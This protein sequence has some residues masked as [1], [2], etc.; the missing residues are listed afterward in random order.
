MKRIKQ[1]F[2]LITCMLLLL[3]ACYK[4][5]GSYNYMDSNQVTFL[6]RLVPYIMPADFEFTIT[7]PI[8]LKYPAEDLN[9]IF[10]GEWKLNGIIIGNEAIL[11]H[12][13][14]TPGDYK[15]SVKL[16]DKKTGQV[17]KSKENEY[18]ISVKY[19]YFLGWMVLSNKEGASKLSY[20]YPLSENSYTQ[21]DDVYEKMNN[22]ASLGSNPYSLFEYTSYLETLKGDPKLLISQ[23]S[24]NVTLTGA[25]LK[26]EKTILEEFMTA[27]LASGLRIKNLGFKGYFYLIQGEDN[28]LYKKI[29]SDR[30]DLYSGKYDLEIFDKPSEITL[31][32]PFNN[33]HYSSKTDKYA[34]LYDQKNSRFIGI[35]VHSTSNPGNITYFNN[36]LSPPASGVLKVNNMGAGTEV[37]AI[38]STETRGSGASSAIR[39]LIKANG[40]YFLHSFTLKDY[41]ASNHR[42]SETDQVAF[43]AANLL[44]NKSIIQFPSSF[45]ETDYF[46]FTAGPNNEQLYVYNIKT[47]TASL[48]YT[49]TTAIVSICAS[50]I[51]N[52]FADFG[53]NAKYPNFK[54]AAAHENGEIAILD[55]SKATLTKVY[56]GIVKDIAQTKLSGFGKVVDM[57][58]R[59]G[60]FN[61]EY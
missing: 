46:Y 56:E 17:Y 45:L 37:L 50:P 20:I 33:A 10:T 49:G 42:I 38:S 15:L 32:M 47:N 28:K 29:V 25:T 44:S 39:S 7:P 61:G 58:W 55:V 4:D 36:Y 5:K 18:S 3:N 52:V 35:D 14:A 54:L 19:P 26:R 16:T 31:M 40:Q 12:K 22:G 24:G 30:K 1:Y 34:L 27:Q 8:S 11:K 51:E 60:G 59:F 21:T 57:T 41:T 48:A 13:I 9:E 23:E 43:K 6:T 2:P 53:G